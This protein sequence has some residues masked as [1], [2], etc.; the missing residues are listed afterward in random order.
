MS[1]YGDFSPDRSVFRRDRL[2][3]LGESGIDLRKKPGKNRY[4]STANSAVKVL[5]RRQLLD[6][7]RVVKPVVYFSE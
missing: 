5:F 7:E 4:V 3:T 1:G 6:R 2:C